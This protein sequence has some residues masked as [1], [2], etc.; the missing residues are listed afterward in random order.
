MESLFLFASNE[1]NAAKVTARGGANKAGLVSD[2]ER[3][4]FNESAISPKLSLRYAEGKRAA[5]VT[6]DD[7]M[8]GAGY[9][10]FAKQTRY[11]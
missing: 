4:G 6:S 10:D 9:L 2:A 11:R 1:G 7:V 8:T 5:S 3:G